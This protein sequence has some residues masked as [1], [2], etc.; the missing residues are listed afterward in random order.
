M[1]QIQTALLEKARAG[2]PAAFQ[3]L[4]LPHQDAVRR[5]AYGFVKDWT[6]ADDLA[7]D[8]LVK[9][10]RSFSAFE[11]RSSISTWLF[12]VTRSV[13]LDWFKTRQSKERQRSAQ[14]DVEPPAP[15]ESTDELL[16][17][18]QSAEALWRALKQLKVEYRVPVILFDIE[19][20]PYQDIA[21]IE[22]VPVGTVR[23]RLSRGRSQLA[24]LLVRRDTNPTSVGTID[25]RS[26]SLSVGN[27]AE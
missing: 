20:M 11:G 18:K 24:K 9:A 10:F 3:A 17:N 16:A 15:L 7:Q 14:L 25:A 26:P 12:T 2:D 8:A 27:P 5:F 6:D 22:G 19:G 23:S 13:C 1:T 4:V 21:R